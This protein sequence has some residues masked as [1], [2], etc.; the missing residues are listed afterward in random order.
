M[1]RN[2][3]QTDYRINLSERD[4]KTGKIKD[5]GFSRQKSGM[6]EGHAQDGER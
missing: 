6:G 5:Q 4:H 2:E 3:K 1:K